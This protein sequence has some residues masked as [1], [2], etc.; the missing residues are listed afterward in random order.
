[1]A[2]VAVVNPD[3][4]AFIQSVQFFRSRNWDG[5]GERVLERPKSGW[6]R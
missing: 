2:K 3:S 1:M 4:M 6:C 5:V